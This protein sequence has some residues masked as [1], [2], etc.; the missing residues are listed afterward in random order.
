[1]NRSF[2]C[3]AAIGCTALLLPLAAQ[4]HGIAGDRIFPATLVMDDPAVGDELSL[5]T[6]AIQPGST[7]TAANEYDYGFEWDKTIVKG[8][9]IAFNAGYT[10]FRQPGSAGGNK[11]GWQDPV[12]TAKYEFLENDAHEILGSVGIQRELGG[13]GAVN[14]LGADTVGWTQ[15]TIYLGKGF[16]DLPSSLGLLRPFAITGELGYQLQDSDHSTSAG[17]A[18]IP[19]VLNPS[20]SLQYSMEYLQSQVKDY[21]FPAFVNNLVPLVEVSYSLPSHDGTP[22]G[23]FAPGILYEGG[24]YQLGLEALIPANHASGNELGVIAQLHFYLDDIF[25]NTLGKPLFA[26]EAPR[27]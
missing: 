25:P 10:S 15:P 22:Q 16:G 14:S 20:F 26:G 18:A 23:Q 21:G 6:V 24:S 27:I 5:P 11:Y 4:A 19:D 3:A 7:G 13:D 2:M 12:I 9:G 8:F 17:G 1:M